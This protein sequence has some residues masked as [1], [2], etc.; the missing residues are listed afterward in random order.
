MPDDPVSTPEPT[1][2]DQPSLLGNIEPSEMIARGLQSVKM[3]S[4]SAGLWQPPTVEECARLFSGYEVLRLLGRGGMGA[5]YQARQVALDRLVAIKLLPL[6]ISVDHDFAERFRREARAMAKLNHPNIIT[7][8]DFG[9]TREGHLFFVMEFVEGANLADV[10]HKVGLDGDQALSVAEQVCKALS[11]AHGKGIIHRDIK[12][13][14]VMIDTDSHVKVADFGLA[15]LTDSNAVEL[16]HTVTGTVLGTPDYMAPEQMKGMDVD[17]RAD[18]YS[19][20]VM[21]YEMIC[22]EVPRGVF[23]PPSKRTG[24]DPRIDQIVIKAMQQA[25]AHRYQSTQELRSDLTAARLPAAAAQM[26][27][28]SAA[29]KSRLPLVAGI[30]AGILAIVVALFMLVPELRL[31]R[32][33]NREN[34]SSHFPRENRASDLGSQT[35]NTGKASSASLTSA[36]RDAPFVNTLGMRFVPVPGTKVL[37]SVWDARVQDYA[38]YAHAKKVADSWTKGEKDGVPVSQGP[39]YPVVVVS[40][41]DAKAFCKWLTEKE[42][43]EDRLPTGAE[44]RLPT[45]EEWSRAVGLTSEQGATPGEKGGK[46]RV[47]YPWGRGFPPPQPKVGNYADSVWHEKFPKEPWLEGYTD[48][49]ATTSPVGSFAANAY[50]LFDMGGNVWQWCEDWFDQNQNGRVVRGA[51]W[52][53]SDRNALLS[54]SR[55]HYVP[56]NRIYHVGFRCVLDSA[57]A[58]EAESGPASAAR[59]AGA[60]GEN[61]LPNLATTAAPFVNTLGMKFVPVPGTKVLFSIWDTR[62]RDY[63][64]RALVNTVDDAWTRQIH[65]GVPVS[66]E[67]DDPVAGVTWNDAQAFCQWLTESEAVAGKLP[68]G[69]KYRLPTDEEW[70]RAVGLDSEPGATPAEKSQKDEVDFPWGTGFPPPRPNLGNYGDSAKHQKFPLER[71]IEG[72]SD[73]Y[74]TT[75]PVASFP[76]NAYGL[77]DMGGNL[78]Q[79][80]ED[81][82][83]ASQKERTMRGASWH[84]ATLASVLLSYRYHAIPGHREDDY[85][86]RCVLELPGPPAGLASAAREPRAIKLWDTPEKI[87]FGVGGGRT[88]RCAWTK[89]HPLSWTSSAAMRSSA[90]ALK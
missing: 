29:K 33:S 70:S 45:D 55:F 88:A 16:G 37:F 2:P 52:D 40:W 38:A 75:S 31:G 54:S 20:G 58:H 47:D 80:C 32:A 43:A 57:P 53:F 85:G 14:N 78:R 89:E 83:D 87:T 36:T 15:R 18:I 76:P 71:W 72:Y 60:R 69:A 10:I 81:W 4:G 42:R 73:G 65:E 67:P 68:K 23:Q 61:F 28:P 66:R 24:C 21:I 1:P 19:L 13:A 86:F 64:A 63:A 3:T 17:H 79:W 49:Y 82:F 7:V 30:V 27:P 26:R 48:G 35:L 5:V 25:P 46:N 34:S 50:G 74:V 77:Y 11:F 12:P 56:W 62:V 22:R 8:Y 9:S 90:L 84:A 44:Y 59:P 41:D 51:S 39:D 6:E